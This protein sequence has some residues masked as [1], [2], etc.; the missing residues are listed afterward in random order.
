MAKKRSV[1]FLI[2]LVICAFT[3]MSIASESGTSTSSNKKDK[4]K[5][6]EA[7]SMKSDLVGTYY[8]VN[9]SILVLFE[10]ENA[11][12]FYSGQSEVTHNNT[13]EYDEDENMLIVNMKT[14]AI[15]GSYSVK[16]ELTEGVEEFYLI[17]EDGLD[18]LRWD[19]E[20]YYRISDDT[21]IYT[22]NECEKLI[23][24]N[25]GT[26]PLNEITA[27]PTPTK[28]PAPTA[29]ATP[30]P[31]KPP[32]QTSATTAAA[33]SSNKFEVPCAISYNTVYEFGINA[34]LRD[35]I[36]YYD[37]VSGYEY[38][39]VKVICN[40]NDSSDYFI[41]DLNFQ[42]Y[43]DNKLC[44][45]YYILADGVESSATVSS[46]RSA[47]IYFA[48][49][50]PSSANSIELEFSPDWLSSEKAIITVK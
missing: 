10:K 39:V 31:T 46:G 14:T 12:Y 34:E 42:C 35:S 1:Y 9:G 49:R 33:S 28:K 40:N 44:D 18:N 29:T 38:V 43:A 47:E 13:W 23:E 20:K 37:A 50:V 25:R 21:K 22:P 36:P 15:F 19:D 17:A 41:S 8:G 27:T 11:D 26:D 32:T 5:E 4:E 3:F 24:E 6:E 45:S 48:Y 16:A 30:L 2:I 7:E